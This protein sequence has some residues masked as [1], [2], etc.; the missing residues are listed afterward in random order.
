MSTPNL[1]PE[2]PAI[3]PASP[4]TM[5][6]SLGWQLR[7]ALPPMRLHSV[8]LF[9][10]KGDA[11]WLSEGALGPDEQGFV[12]EALDELKGNPS[13]THRES[14][15]QDGRGAVFL[16]IRASRA[17]LVG[18]VMILVDGKALNAGGLAARVL[19][20]PVQAILQRLAI[21]LHPTARA[22]ANGSAPVEPVERAETVASAPAPAAVAPA[23]PTGAAAPRS[24]R[25]DATG[26][27]SMEMLAPQEVDQILTF[28][29]AQVTLPA[30]AAP[31]MSPASPAAS[32]PSA[33]VEPPKATLLEIA[34]DAPSEAP[35]VTATESPA[36]ALGFDLR[37]HELVKLRPG[38]RMRRF[39]I[40]P[41]PLNSGAPTG[42]TLGGTTLAGA[43]HTSADAAEALVA[44][45]RELVTWLGTN[46]QLTDRVPLAFALTVRR[47]AM[48]AEHLPDLVADCLQNAA[49][50]TD[51]IGFEIKESL[52][53]RHRAQTERF[54]RTVEQ[55]GGFLVIDDFSFDSGALELLRSKALRLVKVDP[56]LVAAA[57]RDKLAQARIVAISQ[58]ARVLG[59]HCAAKRVDGETTRRWLTAAGFDFAEG[60]LSEGSLTLA[61]LAA[62]LAD[63]K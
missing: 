55:L 53:V 7:A 60:P 57:L 39:Q 34:P 59:V 1:K 29:L 35:R 5:P 2:A 19:T 52:Y 22:T 47:S 23:A 33:P 25:T 51:G 45:L 21:W 15:F 42:M 43:P 50:G 18:L 56:Q 4:S 62:E 12:V 27:I 44:T 61:S 38:G 26:T 6:E 58:A 11:L 32:V 10:L 17:E 24:K 46:S 8:S 30:S 28:E 16:A 41:R 37:V 54:V 36:P 13:R 9:D 48:A 3:E 20:P 40:V 31:P 49:V 14:D 63:S